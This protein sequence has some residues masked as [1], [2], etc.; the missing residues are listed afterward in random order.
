MFCSRAHK[1][2][3]RKARRKREAEQQDFRAG[4]PLELH[5]DIRGRSW[6]PDTVSEEGGYPREEAGSPG[7]GPLAARQRI[8]A[9]RF[10]RLL[11]S[12]QAEEAERPIVSPSEVELQHRNPGVKLTSI[13]DRELDAAELSRDRATIARANA[14]GY[15]PMDRLHGDQAAQRETFAA[16]ARASRAGNRHPQ[17]QPR[18]AAEQYPRLTDWQPASTPRDT[19]PRGVGRRLPARYLN[20]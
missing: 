1:T 17:D 3:H 16:R 4:L 6:Q 7:A 5:T 9:T 11:R 19:D 15:T 20:A 8:A 2:A 10:A 13:R 14:Q 18:P 12:Q